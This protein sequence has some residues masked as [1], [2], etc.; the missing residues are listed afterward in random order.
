MEVGSKPGVISVEEIMNPKETEEKEH[1]EQFWTCIR[2]D[3]AISDLES[4]FRPLQ[5]SRGTIFMVRSFIPK[6]VTNME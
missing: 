5:P 3:M 2:C 4:P 6:R 1:P